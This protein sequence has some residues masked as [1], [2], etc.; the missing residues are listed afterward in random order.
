MHTPILIISPPSKFNKMVNEKDMEKVINKLNRQ[1]IPNYR[2][3]SEKYGLTRTTLMR[4]FLGLCTSRQETTS[5]YHK[6]LTDTQEEALIIQINK[7]II[8][9]MPPTT[10]IVKN[11]VEE[12][13]GRRVHK[14]WIAY[15]VRRYSSR[16]KSLYLC[17]IDNLRVKSEYGPHLEHFF[18]LVA[19]NFSVVLVPCVLLWIIIAN[20]PP[21]HLVE[22]SDSPI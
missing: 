10:K 2:Q 22:K 3:I 17:D 12:V 1:L 13:I 11:L 15:F 20:R 16:L 6:F 14:N 4:R 19:S 5:I 7:L 9:G 18:D 8:R 21:P